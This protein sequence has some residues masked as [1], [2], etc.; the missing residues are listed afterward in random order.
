MAIKRYIDE[1]K[2]TIKIEFNN[3]Q[4]FGPIKLDEITDA[5]TRMIGDLDSRVARL[6]A[7][8]QR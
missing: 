3:G 7:P 5:L 8:S 6:E 1:A 4:T 2:Q